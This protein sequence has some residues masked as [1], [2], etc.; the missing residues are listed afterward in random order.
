MDWGLPDAPPA[1]SLGLCGHPSVPVKLFL[2]V[3][4]PAWGL[5]YM[6]HF[7]PALALPASCPLLGWEV[8]VATSWDRVGHAW[9]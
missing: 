7:L 4:A 1:L 6:V 8:C 3:P 5:L 9:G 2:P